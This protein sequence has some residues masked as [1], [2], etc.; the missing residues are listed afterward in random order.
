MPLRAHIN[1]LDSCVRSYMCDTL[2]HLSSKRPDAYLH[3]SL[4]PLYLAPH[5]LLFL[6]SLQVFF[7][8]LFSLLATGD[9]QRFGPYPLL[10]KVTDDGWMEKGTF[11]LMCV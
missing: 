2:A 3:D 9:T 11:L 8:S 10:K 1:T 5:Y 6:L 7:S 4:R